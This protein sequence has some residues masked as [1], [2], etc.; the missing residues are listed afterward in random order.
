MAKESTAKA[1]V[2]YALA[3]LRSHAK[4]LF[5]VQP[6][7]VD[8]AVYGKAQEFYSVAELQECVKKFLERRVK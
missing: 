7:V 1:E 5:S 8:G 6:E 3:E 2:K 4:E